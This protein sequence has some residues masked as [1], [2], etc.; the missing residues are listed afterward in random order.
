MNPFYESLD[1]ITDEVMNFIECEVDKVGKYANHIQ[2][3]VDCHADQ[4][5]DETIRNL[6][7]SSIIKKY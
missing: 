1:N 2:A 5:Y 3:W 7:K 6:S 4:S